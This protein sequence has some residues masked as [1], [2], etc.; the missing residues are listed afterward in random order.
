MEQYF[1]LYNPL[2]G[3]GDGKFT[4]ECLEVVLEQ[5][6]GM[7]DITKITNYRAFL[8]DKKECDLVICG[9]DGTLHRFVNDIEGLEIPNRILYYAS[10]RDNDFARDLGMAEMGMPIDI[11]EYLKYLPVCEIDHKKYRF[12]NGVGCGF[13]G[14]GSKA[15]EESSDVWMTMKA[16]LF[17]YKPMGVTVEVDGVQYRFDKVWSAQTM[18]GRYYCRGLM[19]VPVR[20]R[21]AD[22]QKLSTVVFHDSNRIRTAMIYFGIYK[23]K[24]SK[25]EKYRTI[26]E[27]QEIMVEFDAPRTI[28]ID[29]EIIKNVSSYRVRSYK[30]KEILKR[31]G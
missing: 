25:N 30:E 7:A 17:H 27:C 20:D 13:G 16:I 3:N 21:K 23:G 12:I 29:G 9:G 31:R 10:G 2:A 14:Y 15:G 18:L 26:L 22:S 1:I 5:V 19:P 28:R 24:H 4:A 11:T 8:E 6:V